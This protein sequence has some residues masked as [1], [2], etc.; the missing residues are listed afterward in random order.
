MNGL[1]AKIKKKQARKEKHYFG[2]NVCTEKRDEMSLICL[3][4]HS[5]KMLANIQN[6]SAEY[7]NMQYERVTYEHECVCVCRSLQRLQFQLILLS[8]ANDT[9]KWK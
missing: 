2:I 8:K 3:L 9:G 7:M 5:A 6:N 4:I 1:E